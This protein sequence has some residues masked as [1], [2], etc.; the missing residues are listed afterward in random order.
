MAGSEIPV[1]RNDPL[2]GTLPPA[3]GG[4][5]CHST[6]FEV[7]TPTTL[8]EL[9]DRGHDRADEASFKSLR[10]NPPFFSA[11]SLLSPMWL[12]SSLL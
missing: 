6:S 9:D 2:G 8:H 4:S 11:A 3:G 7:L 12:P 5:S 10:K 1:C